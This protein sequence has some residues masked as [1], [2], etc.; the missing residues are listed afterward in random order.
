MYVYCMC[1]VVH[2]RIARGGLLSR[3][4]STLFAS[5]G[6]HQ[7]RPPGPEQVA[8]A[9]QHRTAKQVSSALQHN[10]RIITDTE[11]IRARLHRARIMEW[12]DG[13]KKITCVAAA[14]LSVNCGTAT[15]RVVD[16]L[17]NHAEPVV[18]CKYTDGDSPRRTTSPGKQVTTN[19]L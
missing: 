19:I 2:V 10:I 13:C 5:A 15:V 14:Y 7:S 18:D 1:K 6:W 8:L 4:R 16:V 17:R 3:H 9:D 12:T 11:Y